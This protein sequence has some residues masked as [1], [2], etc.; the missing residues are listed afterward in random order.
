MAKIIR[1]REGITS[2]VDFINNFKIAIDCLL[3]VLVHC[4]SIVFLLS[5]DGIKCSAETETARDLT[6]SGTWSG[7]Q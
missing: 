7:E 2:Y 5:R 1:G 6:S 4:L 3:A